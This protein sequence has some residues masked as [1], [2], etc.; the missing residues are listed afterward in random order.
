MN[1]NETIKNRRSIRKF[2]DMPVE[3]E[4]IT[5]ILE[6]GRWAPSGL[7]NQPWR[8]YLPGKAEKEKLAEFTKYSH[9]IKNCASCIC[10]YLD[11]GAVYDRTKDVMAIGACI[12]NMLIT[13][14]ELGLGSCWLGEILNRKKEVNEFLNIP[15][16]YELMAV[17]AFGYGD[18]HPTSRRQPLDTLIIE[19]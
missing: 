16:K 12:Q 3:E 5:R 7:N 6:A 13:A 17:I 4:K 15:A 2:K 19:K 10:V 9:V 18:E 1:L 14:V 11:T 8:F